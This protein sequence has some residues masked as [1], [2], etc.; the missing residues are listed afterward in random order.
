MAQKEIDRKFVEL[1]GMFTDEYGSVKDG[2]GM[3]GEC[4]LRYADYLNQN[5]VS[6]VSWAWLIREMMRRSG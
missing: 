6:E 3:M 1:V 4:L 5:G 2:M